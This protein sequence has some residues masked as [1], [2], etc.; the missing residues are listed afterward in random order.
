MNLSLSKTVQN[1]KAALMA[2]GG[3]HFF[4]IKN[5]IRQYNLKRFRADFT[6]GTNLALMTFPQSMA[7]AMIAGLPVQ[8]GVFAAIIAGLVGSLFAGSRFITLAPS[9]ATAII[10]MSSFA[11]LDMG[12]SEK[13]ALLPLLL[14]MVSGLLILGAYLKVANLIQYVSRSVVVGFVT[15]A[16]IL[17]ICNQSRN[18][19]GITFSEPAITIYDIARLTYHHI[20]DA[21]LYAIII[22]LITFLIHF[23]LN[24]NFKNLP[25]VA[26]TLIVMGGIGY[27]I[28]SFHPLEGVAYLKPINISN[29]G[30]TVPHMTL[31]SMSQLSIMA[32]AIALLC[33]LEGT[34]IGKSLAARSGE[35]LDT[36]QEIFG[37]GIA[38]L[39]ASFLSGMPIAG[40]LTRSMLNWRS[41]AKTA[42]SSFYCGCLCLLVAFV[43]GPSISY[44]P[45]AALA[46]LVIRIGFTLLNR[47]Q[48]RIVTHSTGSDAIVFYSTL[49][50]ALLFPLDKAISFGVVL[51]I[52]LFL[53]KAA[54]P[55]MVEY[56]FDDEGRLTELEQD[57][58]RP[59]PE[60][61]IV[62]VEGNL[63][64][65][66]AELFRDQIRR[67]CEEPYLKVV[68]LRL[69]NAHHLDATGVMALE[70]LIWYMRK[71]NRLL[72]IS[73]A[74]KD[75]VKVFKNSEL[76]DLIGR[77]NIFPDMSQNPNLSTA[78]A[79]KRA[80]QLIGEQKAKV[81]IYYDRSQE[82]ADAS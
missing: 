13:I 74:K 58:Q 54:T 34:A 3:L 31:E 69:K 64:F 59:Y 71:K 70:E 33:I 16:A 44:I 62:H 41:G 55:Q 78:R 12:N 49:I 57:Q 5:T 28:Q 2:N 60:I 65:G 7:Y 14:L 48:I 75:V 30:V 61:S 50:L 56:K 9:N 18:V 42:L 68:V 52:I 10:L 38:N 27:C 17:I 43:I 51:S 67:V 26:L 35:R 79:L 8:Y 39:S 32:L 36:N 22:S 29:W 66:A 40:S 46:V 53:R 19:L 47:K 73:G 24:R 77:E 25:N 63:F 76:L 80:Q 45:T 15:S 82:S 6:A 37:M 72:L 21:N 1:V 20:G 4:P 11:A 23:L 81:S